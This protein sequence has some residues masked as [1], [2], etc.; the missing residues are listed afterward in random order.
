MLTIKSKL[1]DSVFEFKTLR[2]SYPAYLYVSIDG[3][4]NVQVC[5][6][7]CLMGNTLTVYS[8]DD[9]LRTS[10]SWYRKYVSYQRDLL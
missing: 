6:D 5:E 9:L 3:G 2:P 10:R 4:V 7:G 1:L 8:N